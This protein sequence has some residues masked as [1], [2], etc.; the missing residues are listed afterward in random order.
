MTFCDIVVGVEWEDNPRVFEIVA[1]EQGS[2]LFVD[3]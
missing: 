3:V 1:S 2:F